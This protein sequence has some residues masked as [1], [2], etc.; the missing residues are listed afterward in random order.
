MVRAMASLRSVAHVDIG[1]QIRLGRRRASLRVRHGPVDHG[2]DLGVD[3]VEVGPGELTGLGHP[4]GETLEAVQFG[5]GMIDFTGPVGLLVALEMTEVAGEL[6]LQE[7]RAAALPGAGYRLARRLVYR[8]E[9]EAVDDDTGH[10][11]PGG[12][13][14]DVVAGHRPGA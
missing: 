9:V 2:R 8:E 4:G 10:A 3:G 11:E 6:H 13:V 5:P 7:R 1:E 14:G 12:T